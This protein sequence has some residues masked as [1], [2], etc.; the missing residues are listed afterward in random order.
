MKVRIGRV[1]QAA[2]LQQ[3]DGLRLR[4]PWPQSITIS[5]ESTAVSV[6]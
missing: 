4:R 5:A 6:R 3:L 2:D 1:A